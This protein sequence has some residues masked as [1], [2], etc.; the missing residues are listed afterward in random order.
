VGSHSKMM[1][2]RLMSI[3]HLKVQEATY[4]WMRRNRWPS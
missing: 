2:C 4:P 1:I 3:H